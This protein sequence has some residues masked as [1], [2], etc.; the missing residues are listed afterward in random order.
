LYTLS[1]QEIKAK[2]K[3]YAVKE[4]GG[5]DELIDVISYAQ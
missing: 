1:P 2:I 3:H 5:V 4:F